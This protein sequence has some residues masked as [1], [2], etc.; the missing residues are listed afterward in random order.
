MAEEQSMETTQPIVA[1]KHHR[2]LLP[3]QVAKIEAIKAKEKELL[4]LL[5]DSAGDYGVGG[6]WTTIAR[7]N[8][9]LGVM[10]A[11]RAISSSYQ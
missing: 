2:G 6:R 4:S 7:E 9:E 3:E 1:A 8:I 5:Q 11:V 10:A